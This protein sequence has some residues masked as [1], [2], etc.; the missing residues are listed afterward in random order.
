VSCDSNNGFFSSVWCGHVLL[1]P[2][3]SGSSLFNFILIPS[4]LIMPFQTELKKDSVSSTPMTP[5][6][7]AEQTQLFLPRALCL[8]SQVLSSSFKRLGQLILTPP[9]LPIVSCMEHCLRQFM[10]AATT[11]PLVKVR[12]DCRCACSIDCKCV[13]V[14]LKHC[15]HRC[16]TMFLCLHLASLCCLSA[17]FP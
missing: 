1:R 3:F 13:C 16:C 15:W 7:R 10:V 2:C 14:S 4:K 17:L 12:M 9:Q 6:S 5:S 8:V 11:S